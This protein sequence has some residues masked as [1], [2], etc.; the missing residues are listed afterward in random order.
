MRAKRTEY[1]GLT[2]R[3]R[4]ETR[5]ATFLDA[6]Q[7]PWEYEPEKVDLGELRYIPDFWLPSLAAWLEIKGEIVSDPAG[8]T[9]VQKC[10]GIARTTGRACILAFYDPLAAKCAVFFPTGQ[11]YG[12]AHFSLCPICSHLGV[13]IRDETGA[14]ILCPHNQSNPA[15]SRRA[16]YDA[17]MTARG[18]V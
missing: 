4:L 3:S 12:R 10:E 7:V 5:W 18:S 13:W 17:A 1:N 6:L 15:T 14:A 9:I 11:M 2:F 8:L 16:I